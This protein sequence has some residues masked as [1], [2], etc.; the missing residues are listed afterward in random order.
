MLVMIDYGM[1]NTGSINNALTRAGIPFVFS[2]EHADIEKADHLLLCGVGAFDHGMQQLHERGLTELLTRKVLQENT[3]ILGICLG[4]QLFSRSSE[5]GALPGLS[6][7]E[8][9]TVKFRSNGAQLKIP[10]MGWNSVGTMLDHPLMKSIKNGST[11]Y[12][13][14]SYHL[15]P[16]T[17]ADTVA[18]TEYGTVFPSVMARG[19]IAGVQFHPEKSREQGTQLLRNFATWQP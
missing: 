3:P 4:L 10:H 8:A 19:N 6:W 14:H 11:F 17:N 1:G 16:D 13:M 9:D 15:Q 2:G 18:H 5:E 7:L 12:F